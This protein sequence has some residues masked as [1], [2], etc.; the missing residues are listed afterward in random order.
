MMLLWSVTAGWAAVPAASSASGSPTD[1]AAIAT[2]SSAELALQVLQ[3]LRFPTETPRGFTEQQFN[4]MLKVPLTTSGQVWIDADQTMIMEL[5]QPRPEQRRL[6]GTELALS[7][8]R[9]K[10]RQVPDFTRIHHRLTLRSDKAAH[11][12]LLAAGAL[13]Q[14][15]TQWVNEHFSLSHGNSGT[16]PDAP[17]NWEVLLV[18]R[19]TALRTELS[20]IRLSGNGPDLTGM[21][22]DRGTR[23]WQELNFATLPAAN[24]GVSQ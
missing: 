13:L 18:P 16:N 15:N 14:G 2:T 20:W 6:R 21:R 5:S 4:P 9:G 11:L 10:A 23:G 3:Q 8:P 22:A 24:P 1:P 17:T 19:A 12:I 7:R